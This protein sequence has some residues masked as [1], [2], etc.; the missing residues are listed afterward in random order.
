MIEDGNQEIIGKK[1]F[2]VY[3]HS[4]IHD[5]LIKQIVEKE[6]EVY[7]LADHNLIPKVANK[8]PQSIFYINID[9]TLSESEWE[10][11]IKELIADDNLVLD[12]GILSY[13][14]Q[15]QEIIQ[16]YL[17]D[18]GV[19]CGF[20][21]LKMG[22]SETSKI[23]LKLLE[24]NEAKGRRKYVRYQSEP[25]E[26]MNASL[27]YENRFVNGD[28]TDISSVGL[29]VMFEEPIDLLKGQ[30]AENLD[31]TLKGRRIHI[32]AVVIGSRKIG[33]LLCYV[34]LFKSGNN[35]EEKIQKIREFIHISLQRRMDNEFNK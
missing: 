20:I 4:V 5:D 11:K 2:F 9:S 28:I 25:G 34:M 10:L 14:I 12:I 22:L 23:I 8:F 17:I 7:I 27:K 24:V 21:K 33:G 26:V 3:P 15:S 18:I 30:L 32:D 29:G 16:K 19:R 35:H 1:I 6:Y 13:N 31:I